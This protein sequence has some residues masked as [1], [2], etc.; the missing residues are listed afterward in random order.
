[1]YLLEGPQRELVMLK[2]KLTVGTLVLR[3]ER[4]APK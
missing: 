3:L 1:M 2:A 4:Y